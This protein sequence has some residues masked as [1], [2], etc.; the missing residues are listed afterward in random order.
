MSKNSDGHEGGKVVEGEASATQPQVFIAYQAPEEDEIDLVQLGKILWAGK[1]IIIGLFFAGLILA[2][3]VALALPRIYRAKV[4]LFA[5]TMKDV[6]PLAIVYPETREDQKVIAEIYT[7]APEEIY[8]RFL[9]NLNRQGLRY[10]YYKQFVLP[11]IRAKR[12][13]DDFDEYSHFV[14]F[15]DRR[16]TVND[17]PRRGE[18]TVT[19]ATVTLDGT[20]QSQLAAW[21]DNYISF[22]DR[23]TVRN[24]V[25]DVQALLDQRIRQVRTELK[26]LRQVADKERLDRIVQL[27]DALVI[28]KRLGIEKPS[29]SILSVNP[30]KRQMQDQEKGRGLVFDNTQEVPLYFR[31]YTALEGELEQ[32]KRRKDDDAFIYGLRELEGKLAMLKNIQIPIDNLHST[33]VDQSARLEDYPVK[34]RRKL[35]VALS[36]ILSFFLGAIVVLAKSALKKIT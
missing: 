2:I 12:Q 18:K 10:R 21:L 28:A 36:G 6:A 17:R 23:Y 25:S 30:I 15:F 13:Q 9:A 29:G 4:D 16:I 8:Q 11:V 3:V 26:S 22:I 35:I 20:E 33:R 7:P 32:L 14:N 19:A 5:P 31:G 34:P 24:L 27:Q 1:K